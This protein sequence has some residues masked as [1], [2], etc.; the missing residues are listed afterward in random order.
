MP[1]AEGL[2]SGHLCQHGP[3]ESSHTS[4][5]CTYRCSRSRDAIEMRALPLQSFVLIARG[6]YR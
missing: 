6:D 1:A 3:G 2:S 5:A 4:E